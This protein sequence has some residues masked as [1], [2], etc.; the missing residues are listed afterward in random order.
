MTVKTFKQ[1]CDKPYDRH[2]YKLFYTNGKT[3][4]FEYWDEAMAAWLQ[5]NPFVSHIEV[6]DRKKKH[7]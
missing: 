1:T 7:G 4:V 3:V 5:H 2:K 6:I